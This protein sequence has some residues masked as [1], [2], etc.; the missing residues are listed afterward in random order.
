MSDFRTYK[1]KIL[2]KIDEFFVPYFV[3]FRKR[4]INNDDFTIFSNNCWAGYVYRFFGIKYL[5]P[6][7]GGYFFTD[8][9]I[10]FICKAKY[11]TKCPLTFINWKESKWREELQKRNETNVIIGRL[12]DIEYVFLH[13]NSELEAR[14]KWERRCQ[15]INWNNIILKIS[16]QNKCYEKSLKVFESFNE[17]KVCFVN[18]S[19]IDQ[20]R[21]YYRGYEQKNE[22]KNDTYQWRK[23]IDIYEL[24]NRE[25]T[26]YIGIKIS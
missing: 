4:K 2:F 11:Y 18:Y 19:T 25:Q 12:D 7:I 23:F 17:K 14:N 21:I 10:K 13:Y 8:D 22:I 5:T 16:L 24:I 6:T 1:I 9:Y 15:R 26:K 3:K 20:N